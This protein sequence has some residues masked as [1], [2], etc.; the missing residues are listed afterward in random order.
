MRI[1]GWTHVTKLLVAFR[2]FSKASKKLKLIK[3]APKAVSLESLHFIQV[4]YLCVSYNCP[5]IQQLYPKTAQSAGGYRLCY[6]SGSVC[7][8]VYDFDKRQPYPY[9]A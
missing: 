1:D 5:I 7:S 2:N 8:Y 9:L 6:V 4:S 3:Y